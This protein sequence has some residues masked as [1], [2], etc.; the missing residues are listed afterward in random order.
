MKDIAR[1]PLILA[2]VLIGCSGIKVDSDYDP[3][4]NFA[5][6]QK[7]AWLP[8]PRAK[9]GDPRLDSPLLASRIE[10]AIETRMA[11]NGFTKVEP[12]DAD[13]FVTFH[14]GVDQKLDVMTIPT[15]Y[16]YG[17]RRGYYGGVETRVDQYEQGTL[18]I[19][20]V[21]RTKADLLWRGSGQSRV[22]QTSSPEEREQRV[23][24]A[25]NAILKQF[26]PQ[27]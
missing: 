4:T 12:D 18:L 23:R 13:F 5:A 3:R 7:Y 20:F 1:I 11:F 10:D 17:A 2:L 21:D 22:S 14:I 6:L 19:D 26:P 16:G 24:E 27:P 25:V 8:L 15:T 9:T